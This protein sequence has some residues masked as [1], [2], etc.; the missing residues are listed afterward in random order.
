MLQASG[1]QSPL[2]IPG[3]CDPLS[4]YSS[5]YLSIVAPEQVVLSAYNPFISLVQFSDS[6]HSCDAVTRSLNSLGWQVSTHPLSE[7]RKL[8]AQSIILVLDDI[9]TPVLSSNIKGDKWK[10]LQELIGSGSKILWVT[11]GC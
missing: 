10:A 6:M 3:V 4:A 7:L 11:I 8:K 1:F 9:S 5:A 2:R